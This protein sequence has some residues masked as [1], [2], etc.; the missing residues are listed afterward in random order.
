MALHLAKMVFFYAILCGT[1][2][3]N[4]IKN[5]G[6]LFFAFLGAQVVSLHLH[7]RDHS[8]YRGHW[9]AERATAILGACIALLGIMFF[10]HY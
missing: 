10:A 1:A 7:A 4:N 8:Q 3:A 6:A 5:C 9:M 2:Y